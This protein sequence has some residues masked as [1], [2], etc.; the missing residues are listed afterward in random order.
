MACTRRADVRFIA[1]TNRNLAEKVAN[2]GFRRDLY[3]RLSVFPIKVPPLRDRP[4]DI[5]VLVQ[6]FL[7]KH[8]AADTA[9]QRVTQAQCEHLQKYDWPGNVR[10]PLRQRA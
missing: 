7:A 5:P 9:A 8:A 1:A 10:S 4:A 2:G 3:F 6:H